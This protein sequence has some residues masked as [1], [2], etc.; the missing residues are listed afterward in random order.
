M[1]RTRRRLSQ[2]ARPARRR[3]PREQEVVELNSK[4]SVRMNETKSK[5]SGSKNLILDLG[6]MQKYQ[7]SIGC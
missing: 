4:M 7:D 3:G 1:Q 2:A 6:Q 5:K